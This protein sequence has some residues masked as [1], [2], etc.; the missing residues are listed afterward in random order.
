MDS[1]F[2]VFVGGVAMAAT[3][4]PCDA[5]YSCFMLLVVFWLGRA[6]AGGSRR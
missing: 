4:Q 1:A 6:S 3:N 2:Q 5:G